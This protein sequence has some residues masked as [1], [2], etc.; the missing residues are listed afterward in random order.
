MSFSPR[1]VLVTLPVT[2]SDCW[3][4]LS[5]SRHPLAKL[6][7]TQLCPVGPHSH[8]QEE[9]LPLDSER[10]TQGC[11]PVSLMAS[12]KVSSLKHMSSFLFQSPLREDPATCGSF[13]QTSNTTEVLLLYRGPKFSCKV[14]LMKSKCFDMRTG[15]L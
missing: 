11:A 8:A 1:A 15:F 6:P 4:F 5:G 12:G 10:Q 9:A 14:E 7:R 2:V 13:S 3:A